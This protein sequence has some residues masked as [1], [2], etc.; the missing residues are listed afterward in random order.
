MREKS[1]KILVYFC[2]L[3]L[4]L[5]A[6]MLFPVKTTAATRKNQTI[7]ASNLTVRV[8]EKNRKV[9]AKAK[10]SLSYKSSNPSVVGVSPQG[11]LT[12]KK[13]GTVKLTI[14]A[15]ATSKYNSTKRDIT[16][17]VLRSKQSI[18]ASNITVYAGES[19]RKLNAKAKTTLSYKS[20]NPSIV[21]VSPKGVLTPKR[22]GTVTIRINAKATS[23]YDSATRTV[24]VSVKR[25]NS[26]TATL[27]PDRTYRDYDITG[28]QKKDTLLV[29]QIGHNGYAYDNLEIYV[30]GKKQPL[31]THLNYF[32]DA[33][34]KLYTL[35]NGKPFLYIDAAGDN[36]DGHVCALFQYRSGSLKEVV[37]FSDFFGEYGGHKTGEVVSVNK[38]SMKIRFYI[39][40][41]TTGPTQIDF[42]YVYTDGTLKPKSTIG[43]HHSMRML[44]NGTNRRGMAAKTIPVYRSAGGSSKAYTLR[45]GNV[46][47]ILRCKYEDGKMYIEVS[48]NGKK[49]W[50]NAQKGY[51]GESSKLFSNVMYAG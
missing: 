28:D 14:Y 45:K 23:K 51:H 20:S 5:S 26:T 39:M 11:I 17:K 33:K 6:S 18:S 13:G 47:T 32:F 4:L 24:R 1:K 16:V 36:G 3:S 27:R 31:S 12:P 50:I 25:F 43:T 2:M 38:N 48:Y 37:D 34:I 29:R 22:P 10:T 15:K 19:G 49:G 21:G 42:D 30:N 35:E 7:Q 9:N 44:V 41:F 8:G 46:V 40:S